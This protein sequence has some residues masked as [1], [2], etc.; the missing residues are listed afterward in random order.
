MWDTRDDA[1]IAPIL[2]FWVIRF[3]CLGLAIEE[4]GNR[5]ESLA[6]IM[7]RPAFY[8]DISIIVSLIEVCFEEGP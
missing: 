4:T 5:C 1:F 6:T 7:L 3:F 2:Q 8:R